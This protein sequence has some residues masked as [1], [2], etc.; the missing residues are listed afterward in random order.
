MIE[1]WERLGKPQRFDI[2]EYGSGIGGLAYDI[3]AG[4]DSES[5]ECFEATTY[6]LVERNAH[7]QRQALDAFRE[8]GLERKVIGESGD[9]LVTIEGVVLGNEVADAFP[10]HRLVGRDGSFREMWVIRRGD[11]FDWDEGNLSEGGRLAA[12]SLIANGIEP[13]EGGMYDCSPQAAAWFADACGR[14]GRGYSL[15]ID[16]GYEASELYSGH[17]LNGTLRAYREHS[18]SDAPFVDP[19]NHDLTIHVDFTALRRA[20][21]SAGMILGGL[22][23]Q[24]A[25]L[26][27]LGL[28]DHLMALQSEPDTSMEQYLATQAVVRRLIDPGGLGRFRAQVMAKDATVDPPLRLFAVA[29]PSF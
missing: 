1:F 26:A 22:T 21:E 29:P 11:R 14:L 28:G 10:A 3:L 2:R 16:Y 24:G 27:S 12:D 23:T 20:G 9:D 18:V 4:I 6:R 7:R 13:V 5:P 19:G 17:R 15:L 25:A 8:V